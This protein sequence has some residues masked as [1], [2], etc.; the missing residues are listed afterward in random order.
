MSTGFRYI[1]SIHA[2]LMRKATEGFFYQLGLDPLPSWRKF[3]D[4]RKW[5]LFLVHTVYK[6]YQQM[7]LAGKVIAL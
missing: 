5:G 1:L 6:G 3:L 2:T 4:P 7:A